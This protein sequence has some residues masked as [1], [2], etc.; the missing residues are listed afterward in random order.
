MAL[1]M[2]ILRLSKVV[3]QEDSKDFSNET[4][5][6]R[7]VAESWKTKIF[8]RIGEEAT[9]TSYQLD[10]QKERLIFFLKLL[11]YFTIFPNFGKFSLAENHIGACFFTRKTII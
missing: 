7:L 6:W 10:A 1:P 8:E 4:L 2:K 9:R 3:S 5:R 11:L